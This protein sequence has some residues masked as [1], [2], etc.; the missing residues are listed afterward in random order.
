MILLGKKDN[1]CILEI[2]SDNT[3]TLQPLHMNM[4]EGNIIYSKTTL[5]EIRFQ[6]KLGIFDVAVLRAI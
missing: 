2:Y 6:N 5:L 4:E 3:M 1:S